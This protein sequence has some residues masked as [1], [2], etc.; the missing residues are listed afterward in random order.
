M[1]VFKNEKINREAEILNCP[2]LFF[3]RVEGFEGSEDGWA[4]FNEVHSQVAVQTFAKLL[5]WSTTQ[6]VQVQES[7]ICTVA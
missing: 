3:V 4:A 7:E 1:Y 2:H 6:T 5:P